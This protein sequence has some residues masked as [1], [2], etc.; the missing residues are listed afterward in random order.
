MQASLEPLLDE[1]IVLTGYLDSDQRLAAYAAADLF[2]LPATREGLSMAA[3]EAMAAGLPVILSPGC[4][5]REAAA[6]GAGLEVEPQVEPLAK[7][8]RTIPLT[9]IA[10]PM[11][12]WRAS[13][14]CRSSRG[15]SSLRNLRR[16]MLRQEA[17]RRRHTPDSSHGVQCPTHPCPGETE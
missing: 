9:L 11:A 16:C 8:L 4:N 17:K 5:L 10:G 15:M 7:A 14:C 3:L 2:A 6:C 1:R 13:L 12:K